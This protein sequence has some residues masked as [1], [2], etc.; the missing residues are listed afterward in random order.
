MSE[1]NRNI[2]HGQVLNNTSPPALSTREEALAQSTLLSRNASPS[3]LWRE[4]RGE[5]LHQEKHH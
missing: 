1:Q 4:G 5:R 2:S 3:L